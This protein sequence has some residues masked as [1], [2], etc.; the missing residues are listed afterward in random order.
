MPC[1]ARKA[2]ASGRRFPTSQ[3]PAAERLQASAEAARV[4]SSDRR[5]R[6]K[7]AARGG[8][9]LASHTAAS[10]LKRQRR[11][12]CC[13]SIIATVST[14]RVWPLDSSGEEVSLAED[15]RLENFCSPGQAA[16]AWSARRGACISSPRA[17]AA[18]V[19]AVAAPFRNR[20]KG[21]DSTG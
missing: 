17:T 1:F 15:V 18:D 7:P 4:L 5:N 8:P 10:R 11:R 21:V 16:V 19:E 12:R 3:T 6:S 20:K 9:I 14:G 2:G 13:L